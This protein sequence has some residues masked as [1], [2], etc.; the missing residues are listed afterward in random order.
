MRRVY[1]EKSQKLLI[2]ERNDLIKL[3]QNWT[4]PKH[5]ICKKNNLKVIDRSYQL[6]TEKKKG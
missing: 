1:I 4:D 6:A 5:L 2:I 3:L